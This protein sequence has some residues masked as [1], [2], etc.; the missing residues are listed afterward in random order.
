MSLG[1]ISAL[2]YAL[3]RPD[4]VSGLVAVDVGPWVNV[5]GGMPIRAFMAE[6]ATLDQLD[7]FI[8]AALRFNP[9]RDARLLRRSLWH[10]LRRRR[11]GTVMWK[12][13]LRGRTERHETLARSLNDLR[14]RIAGLNC[15]T[16]VVRGGDSKILREE[17]AR[18]FAEAIPNGRW[19]AIAGAGHSV[20]GD[21]PKALIEVLR[22]FLD[23]LQVRG[24]GRDA[25]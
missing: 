18:R 16:L 22:G 10:N 1:G 19:L 23:E 20:Q 24:S 8:A 6:V 4:T 9:R 21:Q 14:A 5:D 13:D 25:N 15:P 17:D 12:T 2:H 7:Q 3:R 11:D